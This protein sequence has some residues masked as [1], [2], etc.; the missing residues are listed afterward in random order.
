MAYVAMLNYE[1]MNTNVII[2]DSTQPVI[3][4]AKNPIIRVLYVRSPQS[5]GLSSPSENIDFS[6]FAAGELPIFYLE[7]CFFLYKSYLLF[8]KLI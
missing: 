7:I 5:V 3:E 8:K 6:S 4:H 2:N 1:N